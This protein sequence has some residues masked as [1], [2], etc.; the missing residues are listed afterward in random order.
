MVW[1]FHQLCK[2]Q[3]GG[4]WPLESLSL[5]LLWLLAG[6]G[7]GSGA[8]LAAPTPSQGPAL[9]MTAPPSGSLLYRADWSHGSAGW[10]RDAGWKVVHGALQ[11]SGL[12]EGR[13]LAPYQPTIGDYAIEVRFR[14][15]KILQPGGEFN[16]LAVKSA[17]SDGYIAG[18]L[19]VR[20]LGPLPG[21]AQ[22]QIILQPAP[23]S[24]TADSVLSSI[25]AD[26]SLGEQWHL[27]R[28]EV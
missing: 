24:Q 27:Y 1:N 21:T 25:P 14:A 9:H 17:R 26:Y 19:N 11:G 10:Q 20:R 12:A 2:H 22:S 23:A 5:F 28:I 13:A 8:P 15:L 3:R 4:T 7:M 6:C 18:V 16:L